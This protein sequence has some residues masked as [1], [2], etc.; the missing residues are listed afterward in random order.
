M[1]AHENVADASYLVSAVA[2]AAVPRYVDCVAVLRRSTGGPKRS[3][4]P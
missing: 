3:V 4:D 1:F 2:A